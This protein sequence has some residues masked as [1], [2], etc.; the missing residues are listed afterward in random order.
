M[1]KGEERE[2]GEKGGEGV[3]YGSERERK[4]GKVREVENE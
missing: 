1:R 2:E 4:E 3:E